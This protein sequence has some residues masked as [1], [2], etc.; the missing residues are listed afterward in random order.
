MNPLQPLLP[1]DILNQIVACVPVVS[2]PGCKIPTP[3]LA[4]LS[5]TCRALTA[6]A[7][8]RLFEKIA[9]IT[10][11]GWSTAHKPDTRTIALRDLFR[12]SPHLASYGLTVLFIMDEPD[13]EY[14]DMST[15]I[16]QCILKNASAHDIFIATPDVEIPMDW[17]TLKPGL[18]EV[19][20]GLCHSAHVRAIRL[21]GIT[22][23]PMAI[24]E[25]PAL[26]KVTLESVY[27]FLPP[28]AG[29]DAGSGLEGSAEGESTKSEVKVG[30]IVFHD[31][32]GNGMRALREVLKVASQL[33]EFEIH[34]KYIYIMFS[35][36]QN[37]VPS[38]RFPFFADTMQ[39]TI[40]FVEP[41]LSSETP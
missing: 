29:A 23:I 34:S 30:T 5:T 40:D 9:L 28:Q 8:R 1:F 17:T 25:A 13:D 10:P 24:L 15:E 14:M 38:S 12:T 2:S 4:A 7:Q 32:D 36:I 37:N 19:L 39:M 3:T 21:R 33:R 31:D 27:S 26:Q 35:T 16:L 18:Q 11:L 22:R 20:V 6:P 41:Q